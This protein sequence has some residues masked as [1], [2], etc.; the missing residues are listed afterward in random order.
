MNMITKLDNKLRGALLVWGTT[1]IKRECWNSEFS[2]GR[3]DQLENTTGD[4]VYQYIE[5]HCRGASILDLGCGSGNTGCELEASRYRDYTGIDIADTAVQEAA[6]RSKSHGRADKNRYIQADIVTY[7]PTQKYDV[8]LFRESLYYIPPQKIAMTLDHYL[9]YLTIDGVF[10]VR[11]WNREKYRGILRL[12][13]DKYAVK[14]RY[15]PATSP[16]VVIV[17]RQD[18]TKTA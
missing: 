17:F 6:T 8:I 15:A 10:I 18:Q 3:W 9:P 13:E 1:K 5:K 14:E 7:A 2:E 11:L 12:I 16:V 4:C